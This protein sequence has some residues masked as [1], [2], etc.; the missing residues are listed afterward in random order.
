[1]KEKLGETTVGQD[2]EEA[3][4]LDLSST[5]TFF[6]NGR[7]IMGL[8]PMQVWNRIIDQL[9]AVNGKR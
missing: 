8:Y 3:I 4:R 9:I 7:K 6:I 2:V 5:P 1:M